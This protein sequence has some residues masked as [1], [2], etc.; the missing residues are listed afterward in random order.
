[1]YGNGSQVMIIDDDDEAPASKAPSNVTTTARTLPNFL[2]EKPGKGSKDQA[3]AN[4][5]KPR[6]E[7][8]DD[9]RPKKKAK[10][11]EEKKTIKKEIKADDDDDDNDEDFEDE[12]EAGRKPKKEETKAAAK[13]EGAKTPAKSGGD[14]EDGEKKEKK[15]W[16]PFNQE[17]KSVPNAHLKDQKIEEHPGS[18]TCF[19]GLTF[20]ITG[21]LDSLERQEAEDL[22]QSHGGKVTKAVS[23][24]T[25]Y[26]VVGDEPGESKL[27]K[28]NKDKTKIINEDQ[29]FELIIQ[30]TAAEAGGGSSGGKAGTDFKAKKASPAAKTTQAATPA[31]KIKKPDASSS[32]HASP[33][34]VQQAVLPL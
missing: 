23:G 33:S 13:K 30:K 25:S 16:N 14:D 2:K 8:D 22:I 12:E 18:E 15:K 5:K 31:A 1:M 11:V 6:Q 17:K 27:K 21:V 9:D 10:N 32:P 34:S 26:L 19:S 20:V 7:E 28:V 4:V 29:L 3:K 24:K